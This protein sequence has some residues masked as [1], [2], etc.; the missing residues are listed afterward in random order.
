MKKLLLIFISLLGI[1]FL[2]NSYA[3]GNAKI[4]IVD[5]Q[6]IMQNA[7]EVK[8]AS[9]ALHKKFAPEQAKILAK[10]TDLKKM[11]DKLNR[12]ASVMRDS[13][14][15][16]LQ[17]QIMTARKEFTTMTQGYEQKVLVAQQQTMQKIVKKVNNIAAQIAKKE[18]L[19]MVIVRQ[20]VIYPGDA[21]DITDEI[22]NSMK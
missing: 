17:D 12:D 3:M 20:A 5:V 21:K 14:K 7:P 10:Q 15:K 13:D 22:I 11:M 2:A 9:D 8:S 4:G 6:K 16:K 18:S 1:F 19:S